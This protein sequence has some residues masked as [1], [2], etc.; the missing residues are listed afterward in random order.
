MAVVWAGDPLAWLLAVVW[1]GDPPAWLLTVV[2]A[3]D[4]PAWL[5]AVVWVTVSLLHGCRL[6]SGRLSLALGIAE[7]LMQRLLI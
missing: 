6:L 7:V 5:P 2:W 4:P 3:G 1:A